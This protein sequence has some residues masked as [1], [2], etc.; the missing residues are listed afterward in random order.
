MAIAFV[1]GAARPRGIG[2]AVALQLA[3]SGHDVACL[4]I[5]RPLPGG[6]GHATATGSDLDEVV[7]EIKS[8]GRRA[9]ALR[10]DVSDEAQVEAAVQTASDE[11]G[12]IGLV[13]NVAGGSGF[14]FGIGPLVSIPADEFRRVLEV[15]LI[16]TWLVSRA[17]ANRM[18]SAGIRGRICNTSSQASKAGF[19]HMGAY[20][21]AKAGINLLTQVLAKE[22]GPQGISVNAVC[23]GTV[24]TEA[25]RFV[26]QHLT[27]GPEGVREYIER[28]IP[29]R[30]IQTPEEIA[31]AIGWLLSEDAAG[32]TG[33]AV[34]V[35]AGQTMV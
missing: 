35:S 16:G 8:L 26:A 21:A 18:I 15:N 17:C 3:R 33:E 5:A 32:V 12:P 25:T 27:G 2:R 1:T 4:D 6:G 22:L 7:A 20:S 29:L 23:P 11:L 13:A 14:G 34:N 9:L 10:A 31:S 24:D 28:E 19:V 30:R